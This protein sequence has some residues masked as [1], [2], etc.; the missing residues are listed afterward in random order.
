M[1]C[2]SKSYAPLRYVDTNDDQTMTHILILHKVLNDLNLAIHQLWQEVLGTEYFRLSP[3]VN[4]GL[5][6]RMVGFVMMVCD[7][8]TIIKMGPDKSFIHLV[9]CLQGQNF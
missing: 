7:Y 5:R 8:I 1:S 3:L 4:L 6:L 2:Y 9:K